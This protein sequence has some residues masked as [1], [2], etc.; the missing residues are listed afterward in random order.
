MKTLK[1]VNTSVG[2]FCPHIRCMLIYG[3]SHRVL[4]ETCEL[5]A[6]Y[7]GVEERTDSL[8]PVNDYT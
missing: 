6:G 3:E 4:T 1:R 2:D 8:P 7:L 5:D